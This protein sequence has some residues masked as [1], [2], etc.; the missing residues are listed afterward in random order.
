VPA[1]APSFTTP[2]E[3]VKYR[4][5]IEAEDLKKAVEKTGQVNLKKWWSK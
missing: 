5:V 3:F 2:K 4:C 1:A